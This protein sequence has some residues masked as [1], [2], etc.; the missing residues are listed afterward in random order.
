MSLRIGDR[1][2]FTRNQWFQGGPI[3]HKI[4]HP[5]F[6]ETTGKFDSEAIAVGRERSITMIRSVPDLQL[7]PRIRYST[8]TILVFPLLVQG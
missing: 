3:R 8:N 1:R 5:G 2:A 6:G 7:V 4:V